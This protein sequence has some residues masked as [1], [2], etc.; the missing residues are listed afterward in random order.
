MI[1][2]LITYIQMDEKITLVCCPGQWTEERS[3][4][5]SIKTDEYKDYI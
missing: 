3:I 1:Y 2:S 5:E 4:N